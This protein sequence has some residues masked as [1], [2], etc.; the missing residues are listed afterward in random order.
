VSASGRLLRFQELADSSAL[1]PARG[2]SVKLGPNSRA[3]RE[4]DI[5]TWLA[6][7]DLKKPSRPTSE[8]A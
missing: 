7:R 8:A 6:S 5:E 2:F 3:W 1:D 4:T